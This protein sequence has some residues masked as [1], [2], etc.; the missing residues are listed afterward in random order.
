MDGG[1]L[2]IQRQKPPLPM[3]RKPVMLPEKY[4]G[5]SCWGDYIVHFE[6]IA[7][8]NGWDKLE[9]A[10]FLGASLKGE[11]QKAF[12]DLPPHEIHSYQAMCKALSRRFGV[13]KQGLIY[14][15]RLQNR[16]QG[17]DESVVEL[18]QAIKRLIGRAYSR[19]PK[20]FAIDVF[21]NA[22]RDSELTKCAYQDRP[23]NFGV[24]AEME[25][26]LQAEKHR[27][28][29]KREVVRSVT[30]GTVGNNYLS[31]LKSELQSRLENEIGQVVSKLKSTNANETTRNR[32]LGNQRNFNKEKVTCW[33]CGERGHYSTDCKQAKAPNVLPFKD[34]P[35]QDWIN[36]KK[37][38]VLPPAMD[39]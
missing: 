13:E 15:V 23:R 16:T 5:S 32:P 30:S 8:I 24:V 26:Y 7:S 3:P 11:A 39:P 34:P 12:A 9:M 20:E 14:R 27:G 19:V 21:G 6:H 4:D 25:N 1:C 37:M 33:N 29:R 35:K 10:N 36:K 28:F 31:D 18:G 22:L 17:P 38:N 2:P